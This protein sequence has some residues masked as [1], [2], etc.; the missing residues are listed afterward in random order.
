MDHHQPMIEEPSMIGYF[1]TD[2]P[3]IKR[4]I[5]RQCFSSTHRSKE[6]G[7]REKQRQM[8]SRL[9]G[10]QNVFNSSFSSK[11]KDAQLHSQ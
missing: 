11:C 6:E 7:W 9:F 8:S 4:Y 5:K 1:K 3:G 2:T 10:G